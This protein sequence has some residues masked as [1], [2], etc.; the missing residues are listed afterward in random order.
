VF[1]KMYQKKLFDEEI[2]YKIGLLMLIIA[3]LS[4]MW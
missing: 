4:T 2:N 1:D 3:S